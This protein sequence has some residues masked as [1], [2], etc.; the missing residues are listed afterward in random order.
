MIDTKG[1]LQDLKNITMLTGEISTVH[2]QSFKRWPYIAFEGV[3]DVEIKYDLSKDYIK[4]VGEG[5]V[6]FYL[7]V[8]PDESKQK[9]IDTRGEAIAG[10]VRDSL[11]NDIKVSVFFNNALV[12]KHSTLKQESNPKQFKESKSYT[13]T[14]KEAKD[15]LKQD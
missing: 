5:Y 1:I 6:E 7:T 9:M 3:G 11:W 15:G 10:W 4:E 12:Y 8:S 14:M 2:E 13:E